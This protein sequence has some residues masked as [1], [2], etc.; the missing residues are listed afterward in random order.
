MSIL[1]SAIHVNF[2]FLEKNIANSNIN[3]IYFTD[4]SLLNEYP[5]GYK[6]IEGSFPLKVD[7]LRI[8]GRYVYVYLINKN[9]KSICFIH[10]LY[11]NKWSNIFTNKSKIFIT[12]ENDKTIWLNCNGNPYISFV[13]DPTKHIESYGPYILSEDFTLDIFK[14][15]I[16]KY[17]DEQ[18]V[19]FLCNLRVLTGCDNIIKNEALFYAKI[20]PNKLVKYIADEKIEKLFEGI[21]IISRLLFNTEIGL[22]DYKYK[23]YKKETAKKEKFNDK[24]LTY[25]NPNEQF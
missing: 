4:P 22:Y 14:K 24:L 9:N 19:S 10:S 6:L 12:T 16:E 25:W 15:N 13:K 20:A 11:N 3:N 18:I 7:K 8:I 5:K 17:K 1:T 21:T 2:E 23:I